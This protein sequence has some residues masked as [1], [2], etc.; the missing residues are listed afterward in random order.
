MGTAK[1]LGTGQGWALAFVPNA[2][3][4]GARGFLTLGLAMIVTAQCAHAAPPTYSIM[5]LGLFD[6]EHTSNTGLQNSTLTF[7]TETG[8]LGGS[9][10]RYSGTASSTGQSAWLAIGSSGTTVRVG[11]IGT[12]YAASGNVAY[13]ELD[14]LNNNG[15][16]A[17]VS[18]RY[19]GANAIG[20]DAWIANANTGV[21]TRIGLFTGSIYG[22]NGLG[23]GKQLSAV[24]ALSQDG[25]VAGY[26]ERYNGSTTL[27]QA[28][29]VA[30]T[31]GTTRQLGYTDAAHTFVSTGT[32]NGYQLSGISF[33]NDHGI[34]AGYSNR[35]SGTSDL[36]QNAWLADAQS[37]ALTQVGMSDTSTTGRQYSVV[38]AL[39]QSG[40]A[41]GESE[42]YPGVNITGR[43]AWLAN[44]TTG[45]TRIGLLDAE[46]TASGQ[47]AT[48]QI[49]EIVALNNASVA[50]GTSTRYFNNAENGQS[51][52]MASVTSGVAATT[53]IGLFNTAEFEQGG[54]ANGNQYS[55][56]TKLNSQ[57]VSIGYSKRYGGSG[58]Q[59]FLG[60]AAWAANAAGGTTRIGVLSDP[61]QI[62][63]D[64]YRASIATLL[65][66]TGTAGGVSTR[67]ASSNAIGQSA[68]LANT[69]SG[70]TVE[71]GMTDAAHT[72]SSSGY[73]YSALTALT[74][75]GYAAGYSI[76]YTSG[77]NANGQT[78]WVER[79]DGSAFAP[80]VLSIRSTDQFAY[81]SISD[82]TEAGLAVGTYT[83]F[84]S[85][86]D[87]VGS[88]RA[89]AW[90]PSTGAYDLGAAAPGSVPST[91]SA[92]SSA[93][94][95]DA[96][97][98]IAG[99][100]TAIPNSGGTAVFAAEV[101]GD[102][103]AVPEPGTA[104]GGVALIAAALVHRRVRRR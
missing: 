88:S 9:S 35:F 20:Q 1:Q 2:G 67:Y 50:V 101:L 98:I 33:L 48:L 38:R 59:T 95:A 96:L 83:Y 32:S 6:A 36:G 103:T 58:G 102:G 57:S 24:T 37:G 92:L 14:F 3:R 91:W 29:W 93:S 64:G 42:T 60:I 43:S 87:T 23:T 22:D 80:I 25:W 70:L 99:T 52:F 104:L 77:G 72:I 62:R 54:T 18:N 81:S 66:N 68:W 13:S 7:Q 21:T 47:G 27:G 31:S 78:A 15:L 45:T 44:P 71:A 89:F 39:N 49:S 79:A 10:T 86:S 34:A 90:T 56:V 65:N 84:A 12:G 94:L 26:S 46:H 40:V 76:S 73:R 41:A 74:D 17:G 63:S 30:N 28:A 55:D 5:R 51:A 75:S 61:A 97:G 100:G 69:S 16:G 82:L 53:R 19:F 11:L 85:S 4:K 8:Y